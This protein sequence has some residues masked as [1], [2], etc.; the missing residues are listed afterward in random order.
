M[1]N[2][3]FEKMQKLAFGKIN[4]NQDTQISDY[5]G[6]MV[7]NQPEDVIKILVSLTDGTLPIGE[8]QRTT[9]D[10][11]YDSFKDDDEELD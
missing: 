2:N 3:D 9:G 8:F 6:I 4:E 5:W 11:I 10:D 1:K 7:K